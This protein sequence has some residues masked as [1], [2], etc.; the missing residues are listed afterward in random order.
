MEKLFPIRSKLAISLVGKK[1]AQEGNKMEMKFCENGT[2]ISILTGWK[3]KSE[4]PP[5]VV[6]LFQEISVSSGHAVCILTS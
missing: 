5:K 6:L 2:V 1:L 3:G 4:V